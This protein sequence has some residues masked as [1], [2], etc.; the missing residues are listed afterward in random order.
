MVAPVPIPSSMSEAVSSSSS[1]GSGHPSSSRNSLSLMSFS[2]KKLSHKD[3]SFPTCNTQTTVVN[4]LDG[5]N[6]AASS[7]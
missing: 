2:L 1:C 6:A 7:N 3:F 4:T 5:K